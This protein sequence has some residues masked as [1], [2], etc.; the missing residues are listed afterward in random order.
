MLHLS[1]ELWAWYCGCRV[2][3]MAWAGSELGLDSHNS[4]C[5]EINPFSRGHRNRNWYFQKNELRRLCTSYE[6]FSSNE[7]SLICVISGCCG[8]CYHCRVQ[9]AREGLCPLA[10]EPAQLQGEALAFEVR[11]PFRACGRLVEKIQGISL[12]EAEMY[13][14]DTRENLSMWVDQVTVK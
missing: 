3:A 6:Y 11:V 5:Q 9:S 13:G 1:R 10:P 2:I 14:G 12:C 4:R 8:A 7:S